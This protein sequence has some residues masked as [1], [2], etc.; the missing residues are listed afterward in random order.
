MH[1]SRMGWKTIGMRYRTFVQDGDEQ[2]EKEGN[3]TTEGK[4]K[5]KT[6]TRQRWYLCRHPQSVSLLMSNLAEAITQPFQA[7][8]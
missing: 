3:R 8:V 5:N 2:R 4:T 1:P 6:T 7:F